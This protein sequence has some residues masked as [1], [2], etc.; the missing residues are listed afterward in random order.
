MRRAG[1]RCLTRR[2]PVGTRGR[3]S[4][5]GRPTA[6]ARPA[7]RVRRLLY[8]IDGIRLI[9]ALMVAVHHYAGTRRV[10]QPGNVI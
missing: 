3:H 9:A 6:T 10:D 1:Y 8:A 2:A 7:A 4:D 5:R